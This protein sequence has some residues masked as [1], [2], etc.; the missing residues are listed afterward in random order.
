MALLPYVAGFLSAIV[1]RIYAAY[2]NA[3][4]GNRYLDFAIVFF[5]SDCVLFI[6]KLENSI[7]TIKAISNTDD[8]SYIELPNPPYDSNLYDKIGIRDILQVLDSSNTP[9][10]HVPQRVYDLNM[11]LVVYRHV[12]TDYIGFKSKI[13]SCLNELAAPVE[14]LSY[15]V[16]ESVDCNAKNS[17]L[18]FYK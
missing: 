13:E 2:L 1:L 12:Y 5:M 4:R 18:E 8:V 15:K 14:E 11:A 16:Q 17:F 10:K 6:R 9:K 7:N 3:K